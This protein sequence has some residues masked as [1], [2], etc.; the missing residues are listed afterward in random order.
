M[1]R[2]DWLILA[3]VG[4]RILVTVFIVFGIIALVESLNDWRFRHLS[5]VGGPMLGILA[6]VT[7]AA[8]WTIKTLP[9]SVLLG[10]IIGLL[11]LQSRRELTV[12]KSAGMSIWRILRAPMVAVALASVLIAF[13][14]EGVNTAINRTLNPTPP[15]ESGV[16]TPPGEIWLVQRDGDK[17]YVLVGKRL[18][19][20]TT[21]LEDVTVYL[22]DST[23]GSRL[24]APAAELRVG[25]WYFETV[26]E[27]RPGI[28]ARTLAAFRLPTSSTPA[29]LR[30]RLTSPE[31]LTFAELL[32]ALRQGISDPVLA[33]ATFMRLLRLI[34]M[35]LLLTGSL[36]IA[37]AFT[38][39][40]RR[41][42]KFGSA[43]L[44]GILLGFLVF[45]V[46]EM[47]DRAGSAGVLQPEFAAIGPALVAIVIGLT[48]LLRKEDGRV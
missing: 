43:I 24:T 8:R 2:L 14:V 29:D 10:A 35:P 20:G 23:A 13:Y 33:A 27:Q 6:I 5:S 11:D 37:F 12:I 17:R 21:V 25:E 38:A 42:N 1:T 36:F 44:Y 9:V 48:V 46:T 26:L 32:G 18:Q 40:Y 7:N 28:P 19:P 45:V 22:T 31:D 30:L 41:T 15:G 47:A 39:G 4:S 3:R 16:L 34:T